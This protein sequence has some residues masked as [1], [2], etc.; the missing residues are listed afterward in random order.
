ML[1]APRTRPALD[2]GR[3]RARSSCSRELRA[4]WPE[5]YL[6]PDEADE[7]L[8]E[9][10]RAGAAEDLAVRDVLHGIRLGLTG[11]ERGVALR[12]VVA[13]IEREEAIRMRAPA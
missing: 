1:V 13:A 7:L 12:Y 10:K 2:R 11:R 8:D 9:L 5:P 3:A 6:A 4:G